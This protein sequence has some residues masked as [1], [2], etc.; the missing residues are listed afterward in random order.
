M[1]NFREEQEH[2]TSH[3]VLG[4][5]PDEQCRSSPELRPSVWDQVI[6][7]LKLFTVAGGLMLALWLIDRA[8]TR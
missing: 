8:V 1:S 5:A 2:L 4:S 7:G 3:E 6:T